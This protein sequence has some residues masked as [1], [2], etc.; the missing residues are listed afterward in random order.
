[1]NV[2]LAKYFS[3]AV[4]VIAIA[5]VTIALAVH[6]HLPRE[7]L[8]ALLGA[9]VGFGAVSGLVALQ[10]SYFIAHSMPHI[11]LF[12]APLAALMEYYL[13]GNSWVYVV[14]I[15]LLVGLGVGLLR[16]KLESDVAASI[17]IAVTASLSTLTIYHAV[18]VTGAV[19]VYALVVG[20]PLLA[21]LDDALLALLVGLATLLA[22][23]AMAREIGLIGVDRV[24]A[25][26]AGV[27]V[28]LYESGALA[29]TAIV[30][31]TMVKITGYLIV[32]VSL[33]L[34]GAV[35]AMMMR[36]SRLH[37]IASTVAALLSF[38]VGLHVSLYLDIPI[39]A[40]V[41]IAMLVMFAIAWVLKRG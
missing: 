35:S 12:A 20:D 16:E 25:Y 26:S 18:T 5:I 32:A 30:S 11:V 2:A 6:P 9:A 19:S 23:L 13:G 24:L 1:M 22:S 7:T 40:G 41:G 29:L 36:G 31:A 37:V 14:G 15:T 21:T 17:A 4:T 3:V 38:M 10:R 28:R 39:S 8:L 33:L 27:K 34:P